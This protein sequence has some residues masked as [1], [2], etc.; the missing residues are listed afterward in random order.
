MIQLVLWFFDL[1]RGP[2]TRLGVDYP[3]FRAILEVKLTMDNRRQLSGLQ[4]QSKPDKPHRATYLWTL[5]AFFFFGLMFAGTA[6]LLPSPLVGMALVHSFVMAMVGMTLIADYSTV[7]LDTT[8]NMVMQPRPIDGRTILVARVAH[9]ATYLSMMAFSLSLPG[10]I[11]AMFKCHWLAPLV[12]VPTVFASLMLIVFLAYAFYLVTM[13][14]ANPERLRDIITWVQ[15][16]L[17]VVVIG[18][19]QILP[20]LIGM[21]RLKALTLDDR[22][23]VYL[24]PPAWF[25]APLDLLAGH[26]DAMRVIL[27]LEGVLLPIGALL[28]VVRVMAPRFSQAMLALENQPAALK[29]IEQAARGNGRSLAAFLARCTCRKRD[30]RAAFELIWRMCGRDRQFKRRTYP[31]VAMMCVMTVPLM[32]NFSRGNGRSFIDSIQHTNVFIIALY[33]CGMIVPNAI[34]QICL[35]DQPDA[36]WFYRVL[37]IER[38]GLILVAAWKV[39]LCRLVVPVYAFVSVVLLALI[40]PRILPDLVLA[41]SGILLLAGLY[42]LVFGRRFPFSLPYSVMQQSGRVVRATGLSLVPFLLAGL[43]WALR[44]VPYGVIAV[45]PFYLGLT[46]LLLFAIQT[47]SWHE[48]LKDA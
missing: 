22:P 44:M 13:R 9:V 33:F 32:L 30:A 48:V 4:Q 45:I 39:V 27:T 8:D 18:G 25:A 47:T 17:S 5:F 12:F 37:P 1:L 11:V 31:M 23:W 38:P 15:I 20:R 40:G 34:A 3:Q 26:V 16:A 24:F 41:F 6:A 43:H 19:Y 10:M 14:L 7:L 21:E 36:A 46:A 28:L 29:P 35:S 2:I 42:G